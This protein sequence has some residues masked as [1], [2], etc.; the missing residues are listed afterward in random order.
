MGGGHHGR[1]VDTEHDGGREEQALD[2]LAPVHLGL[3]GLGGLWNEGD[4]GPEGQG[5]G[6]GS[7]DA[8]LS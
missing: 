3:L 2:G 4:G 5:G 7:E 8:L 1:G 6:D